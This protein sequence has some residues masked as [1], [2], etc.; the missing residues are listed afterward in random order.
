MSRFKNLEFGGNDGESNVSRPEPLGV[1]HF[2]R[3][4]EQ[5]NLEGEFERALRSYARALEYSP[6]EPLAWAGQIRMLI[7]L[8][9]L[10]GAKALADAALQRLQ[11]HPEIL[12]ARA[13][14]L[15]RQRQFEAAMAFSDAAIEAGQDTPGVWLARGDV[16]LSAGNRQSEFCFQQAVALSPGSWLTHWLASRIHCYYK[17]F[18]LALKYAQQALAL[19]G[20]Q[21][22]VWLQLGIC[23][24][25]LGLAAPAQNSFAQA[26][27][28]NPRCAAAKLAQAGA[29]STGWVARLVRRGRRLWGQ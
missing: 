4:A 22:V 6:A 20:A 5:A 28:L 14:A 24:D 1:L 29:G 2:L 11:N 8:G 3:E 21:C 15:G 25:A 9:N 18:S 16:L 10:N 7:E 17:K 13:V 26:L 23:Q 19:D 12:A 27:Q